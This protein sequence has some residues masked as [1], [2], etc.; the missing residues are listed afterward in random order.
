MK[1]SIQDSYLKYVIVLGIMFSIVLV[2]WFVKFPVTPSIDKSFLYRDLFGPTPIINDEYVLF[3][4]DHEL[5][6]GKQSVIKKVGCIAG[7][8]LERRAD[9]FYCND[10][11]LKVIRLERVNGEPLPQFYFHGVVPENKLFLYGTDQYSFGSRHWG[12][13][14]VSEAERLIPII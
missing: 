1:K 8:K 14:D 4:H 2:F 7:Q 10:K 12:F 11:F 13:I 9:G 6:G 3:T 5:I